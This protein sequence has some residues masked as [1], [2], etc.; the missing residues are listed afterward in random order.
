MT[1][2]YSSSGGS[3]PRSQIDYWNGSLQFTW[4]L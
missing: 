2:S 1:I 4:S 3:S